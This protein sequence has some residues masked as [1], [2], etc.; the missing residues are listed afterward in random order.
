MFRQSGRR[1][2]IVCLP[3]SHNLQ[4]YSLFDFAKLQVMLARSC[5]RS[6]L[7]LK[8][9][10][11]QCCPAFCPVPLGALRYLGWYRTHL[12]SPRLIVWLVDSTLRGAG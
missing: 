7:T 4:Q 11:D 1:L 3:S 12:L 8:D 6:G 10:Q 9:R 5:F 2:A